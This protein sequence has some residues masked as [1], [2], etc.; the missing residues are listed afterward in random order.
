MTVKSKTFVAYNG[1]K[2]VHDGELI[3]KET[4][5]AM[6]GGPEGFLAVI[7]FNAPNIYQGRLNKLVCME[8]DLIKQAED[9]E[10]KHKK[11]NLLQEASVFR[12]LINELSQ[13]RHIGLNSK[14]EAV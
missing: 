14:I 10:S 1:T 12:G 3:S 11:E 6:V 7:P 9:E 5:L 13:W 2:V 8:R 4:K